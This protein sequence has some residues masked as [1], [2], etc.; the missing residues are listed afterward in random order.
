MPA[1]PFRSNASHPESRFDTD[2]KK[3][4]YSVGWNEEHLADLARRD[5]DTTG[6]ETETAQHTLLESKIKQAEFELWRD[7][8]RMLY[9]EGDHCFYTN[10]HDDS[11]GVSFER[12][13]ILDNEPPSNEPPYGGG[14]RLAFC[15][16]SLLSNNAEHEF[17]RYLEDNTGFEYDRADSFE[18]FMDNSG[19]NDAI[20]K[21]GNV[22]NTVD[23]GEFASGE[24]A[25]LSS[26]DADDFLFG[27]L[28]TRSLRESAGSLLDDFTE[29]ELLRRAF[30]ERGNHNKNTA[31]NTDTQMPDLPPQPPRDA[32]KIS[33]GNLCGHGK[34]SAAQTY[35]PNTGCRRPV[36]Q[37]GE[38]CWQHK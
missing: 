3:A 20:S 37:P 35:N 22:V 23:D 8:E 21:M 34:K 1:T 17:L 33:R 11:E 2:I 27:L 18:R 30:D 19:L 26:D 10:G 9:G 36:S 14:N 32:T 12:D 15:F 6:E 28:C 7:A 29:D 24:R 16:D 13:L 5:N 4:R 38:R 25:E 31:D